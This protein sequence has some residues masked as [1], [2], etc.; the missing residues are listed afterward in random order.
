MPSLYGEN[1]MNSEIGRAGVGGNAGGDAFRNRFATI[2][3]SMIFIIVAVAACF[4]CFA[5]R[6][7]ANDELRVHDILEISWRLMTYDYENNGVPDDLLMLREDRYGRARV[8][9]VNG[10]PYEYHRRAQHAYELCAVFSTATKDDAGRTNIVRYGD[11]V[12]HGYGVWFHEKGR[13]CLARTFPL[14]KHTRK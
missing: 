1:G 6:E 5:H 12:V 7:R 14:W 9:P 2:A 4:I 10:F 11:P 3:I 8:D 13:Q